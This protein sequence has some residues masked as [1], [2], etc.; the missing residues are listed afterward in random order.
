MKK[1]VRVLLWVTGVLAALVLVLMTV[2]QVVLNSRRFS[3]WLDE[4]VAASLDGTLRHAPL[5]VSVFR[6]FPRIRVRLDSLSLT[7]PHE[8]F[9][10]YDG[11]SAPSRLLDAGRGEREDTLAAFRHF[12]AAVNLWRILGGRIRLSDASLSG[13]ALYAHAYDSTAANWNIFRPGEPEIED[14]TAAG[15]PNLPW[16]SVGPVRVD[17]RSHIVFTDQADTLYGLLAFRR[18]QLGGDVRL[19][20]GK[21]PLHFRKLGF[22]LDSL[23]VHGRLPAD[24]LAVFLDSLSVDNPA[25]HTLDLGLGAK[26]L[27]VSGTFGHLNIPFGLQTRVTYD[28]QPEVVH[29]GLPHLHAD[30]AYVPIDAKGKAD[31][32]ADST[33]VQGRVGIDHA[34]LS[35]I[36]KDYG[37]GLIAQAADVS[38]DARIDLDVS[39]DGFLSERQV[40]AV[41]LSL[42]VPDSHVRYIPMDIRALMGMDVKASL[43]PAQMLTATVDRFKFRMQGLALD[44]SGSGRDLLGEDPF[45]RMDSRGTACLDTLMR[46][47]PE[48]LGL[49]AGG[50]LDLRLSAAARMS[51]LQDYHFE[52][53]A[54]DGEISSP[55]LSVAM[56]EDSLDAVLDGPVVRLSSDASGILAAIDVDS[57]LLRQGAALMARVRSMKNAAT[58]S[59]IRTASGKRVP[60]FDVSSENGGVFVKSGVNRMGVRNFR[61]AAG[62]EKRVRDRGRR[63]HFLDSLQRVYPGVPRDSL[64]LRMRAERRSRPLPDFL[65]ERDFAGKDIDISL[66]SAITKYLRAWKPSGS[67]EA[68]RGFVAT[69]LLPLRTRLTGLKG[70]FNDD[71]LNLHRFGITSGTSDLNASGRVSGLRRALQRKGLLRLNLDLK[72]ER[73]NANELLVAFQTGSKLVDSLASKSPAKEDDESFVTDTLKDAKFASDEMSLLVVPANLIARLDLHAARVDYSDLL[74]KPLR[75]TLNLKERTLQVTDAEAQTNLGLV[76]LNAFYSTRTKKDISMGLDLRMN[77][78]SAEGIIKMIPEVDQMMPMLKSF[79]GTLGCE[80]SATTQ[81][82]TNMNVVMPTL[83]GLVRITGE[84]LMVE[85]AGDLRKITR[86]LMFRN[87]NIGRI[88]NL[89]VNAVVKDSK[90]E[91]YPF[92]LGVDRYTLA[93]MGTQ[94]FDGSMRYNASIIRSP[95]PFRF[96]INV[97]GNLD[98]WRFSLGRSKYRNGKVPVFTQELDAIQIN[99][100]D[101]IRNIYNRGVENAMAQTVRSQQNLERRRVAQGYTS[102]LP[103]DILSTEEYRQV[104]S[105]AFSVDMEEHAQAVEQSAAAAVEQSLGKTAQLQQEYEASLSKRQARE[106]RKEK[107]AS[108]KASR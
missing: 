95:L 1:G 68:E 8:R 52:K 49:N 40:P 10:A 43:T 72:S 13:L 97:Y 83:D 24:T 92:V 98:K 100:L 47:V 21:R 53:A 30:V 5:R 74:V 64:V 41:D 62:A 36:L 60:R 69:P 84:D 80:V 22:R 58:L 102:A 91:I 38:T 37:A 51:E 35:A 87:K 61:L 55:R 106:A 54:I 45:L 3:S 82:D 6:T 50:D 11:L 4:T 86:L 63:K 9:S 56:P 29:L 26:A 44:L 17:G 89:Y 73:L 88:Q 75:A 71:V 65:T 14:T 93:L 19:P 81:I 79:K 33:Y 57:L 76:G 59:K 25:H 90:L 7:Y 108:Q 101:A 77:E 48:G 34:D 32:Y 39:V 104:D 94:G 46:Y 16:I 23:F 67:I 31:L 99:I 78:M 20:H 12:T 27:M 96:G 70:D 18:M 42:R 15:L 85:D 105:I 107:R 103:D 66:D 28:P 2:L